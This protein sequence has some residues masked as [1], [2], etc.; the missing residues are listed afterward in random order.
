[1]NSSGHSFEG[2]TPHKA[3][4]NTILP[5]TIG[6]EFSNCLHLKQ[7]GS[8]FSVRAVVNIRQTI[9]APLPFLEPPS[10][11]QPAGQEQVRP[12]GHGS[13]AGFSHINNNKSERV[14]L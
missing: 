4:E 8:S 9:Y 7:S 2:V 3:K 10:K 1:M 11:R 13:W 6:K 12:T 5:F 14:F